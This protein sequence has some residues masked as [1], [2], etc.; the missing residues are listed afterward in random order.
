MCSLSFHF[1]N[2]EKVQKTRKRLDAVSN[3]DQRPR[4]RV[5]VALPDVANMDALAVM[6]DDELLQRLRGLE[7]GRLQAFDSHID[8]RPWEEE[9]AYVRR[10]QQLRRRRREAH[11]EYVRRVEDEYALVESQLPA[12]D[13]DNL[14]YVYA[15][16][17]GRPRWN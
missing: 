14:A 15:A 17:G 4:P 9:L 16:T 10:E 13:F 12:G 8:T 1:L 7:D 2:E 6:Q 3:V 5:S 11:E